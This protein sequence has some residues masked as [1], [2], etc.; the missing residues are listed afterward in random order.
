MVR[1][2]KGFTLIELMVVMA[3]IATLL[4]LAV[5]RYFDH[6]DRAREATLR[7]SLAV[8]REAIDKYKADTG[9]YPAALEDLVKRRYLR[10]LPVDPITERSDSW[11]GVAPT[12]GGANQIWD[13]QS[14]AEGNGRDGS[15]YRTW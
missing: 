15:E 13:V 11:I 2:R 6:L 4:T 12:D 8:M 14:G 3:V 10:R 5:P 7:E 9:N 1:K